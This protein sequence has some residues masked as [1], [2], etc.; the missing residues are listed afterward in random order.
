MTDLIHHASEI[1]FLG[2]IF[3]PVLSAIKRVVATIPS[4]ILDL[5][6][7]IKKVWVESFDEVL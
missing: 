4:N 7:K 3:D 6:L 5:F 2:Y 1:E